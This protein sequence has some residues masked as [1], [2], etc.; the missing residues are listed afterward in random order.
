LTY[1]YFKPTKVGKIKNRDSQNTSLTVYITYQG[2]GMSEVKACPSAAP[3][4]ECSNPNAPETKQF[5]C[6]FSL[7][8]NMY[9]CFIW[10]ASQDH[11]QW[12]K[13]DTVDK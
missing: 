10:A 1:L 12:S 4:V 13:E 3:K 9:K 2:G 7:I 6:L 11:K 5:F 8:Q